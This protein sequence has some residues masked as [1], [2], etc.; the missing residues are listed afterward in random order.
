MNENLG[1]KKDKESNKISKFLEKT[2]YTPSEGK[3]IPMPVNAG[4]YLL[5]PEIFGYI[6]PKKKV[7]IEREVF[8]I[9]ASEG[10]LYSYSIPGIWKDIGKPEE[11]LEGNIQ[12]MNDILKNLEE[13]KENLIDESLDIEGKAIINPPV[14]IGENVVIR[15]NCKIGPNVIIG[16]N[17]Y[18]GA[19]TEIKET[20]IY[21]EAYLSENIKCEKAIIAD[22]CLLHDGVQLIGNNQNLVILSSFVEVLDNVRLIAP[23][24]SSLTVCHHDVVRLDVS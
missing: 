10:K 2:E 12:L 23:P 5:E 24:T 9:L 8:P 22:N 13:K 18:V 4:V 20:L 7:S 19:N 14:T 16:D 21:N 1:T 17:V 11:L 15:K 6:K 3:I